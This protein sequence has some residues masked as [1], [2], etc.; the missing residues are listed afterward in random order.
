MLYGVA[1][2]LIGMV[3][4][5]KFSGMEDAQM[6]FA[7]VAVELLPAGLSGIVLAGSLSALMSTASGPLLASST[8]LANDICK[9][10][11]AEDI[12]DLDFLRATP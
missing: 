12:T 4:A 11:F 8:L 2:A 6:A 5:V 10:F 3:A 1:M 7:T 9:R